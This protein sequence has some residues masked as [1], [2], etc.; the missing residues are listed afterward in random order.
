MNRMTTLEKTTFALMGGMIVIGLVLLVVQ[1]AR[2]RSA[3]L[4]MLGRIERIARLTDR[5]VPVKSE[6]RLEPEEE[7]AYGNLPRLNVNTATLAQL[8]GLPGIGKTMAERIIELR[9]VKGGF[10]SI[11]EL[12]EIKGLS[13][14]KFTQ[15]SRILTVADGASGEPKKLNLNFATLDELEALPGVGPK[16][17]RAIFDARNSKGGF[18]SVKD[19]E[20]IPGLTEKKYK[21]FAPLVE[22][23]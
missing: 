18:R 11:S 20:D 22:I 2:G 5:T 17:A 8:D 21:V 14:K 7:S 4:H 1:I 19:L 13:G 3:N 23:K 10:K 15:V 12:K 16:L 6:E 9:K